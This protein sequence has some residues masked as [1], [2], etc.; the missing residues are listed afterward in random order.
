VANYY[1]HNRMTAEDLSRALTA[2]GMTLDD[3]IFLTGYTREQVMDW[4]NPPADVGDSY[5]F[6]IPHIVAVFFELL[7]L[8]AAR[9]MAFDFSRKLVKPRAARKEAV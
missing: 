7:K 2:H 4:L 9:Q 3:F 1:R 8:G 5:A 6:Q